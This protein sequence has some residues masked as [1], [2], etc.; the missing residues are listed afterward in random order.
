MTT[1]GLSAESLQLRGALCELAARYHGAGWMMGTSGN[2]SARFDGAAGDQRCVITASGH[3]K[4]DLGLED[5]VEMSL[6][7]DTIG[8]GDGQRP[9]AETSIHL[10]IYRQVPEARAVLHVH[11]V[12]STLLEA[13]AGE[14]A[15]INFTG[16]EMVKG[17][18]L[19]GEGDSAE[20]PVFPNHSEVPRIA[21]DV[22]R[23]LSTAQSVPAMVIR[24][25]GL[26]A[27]GDS[28]KTADRHLEVAE[29]L[30]RVAER[31]PSP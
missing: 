23:W 30:C 29:F 7:G 25:H 16:Y 17:W 18:G 20:L 24:R 22:E 11:T 14:P 10:A 15:T 21:V 19:W 6:D 31:R 13:T 5:F 1:P 4:G 12:A 26:T 28:L 8:A 2:L 27:W 3:P 9:S